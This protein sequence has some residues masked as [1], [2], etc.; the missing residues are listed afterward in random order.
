MQNGKGALKSKLVWFGLLEVLIA[1]AGVVGF[2]EYNPSPEVISIAAGVAGL[3][4][5]V[6]RYVTTD[7]IE[8]LL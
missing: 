1:V 3:V 4:T 8:G 6:L 5:I 2:V 7:R